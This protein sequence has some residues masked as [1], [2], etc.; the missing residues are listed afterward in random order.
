MK[1]YNLPRSFFS[2]MMVI[3]VINYMD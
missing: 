1:E 3:Y 2:A